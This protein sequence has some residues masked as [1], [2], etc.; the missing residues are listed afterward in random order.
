M[1][2]YKNFCISFE[3]GNNNLRS[4][5][6]LEPPPTYEAPPNYEEVIKIG[7]DEQMNKLKKDGRSGRKSRLHRPR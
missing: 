7:M 3:D 5:E 1:I 4:D 6:N 2:K